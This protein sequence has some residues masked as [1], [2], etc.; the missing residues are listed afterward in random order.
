MTQAFARM[1]RAII[2]RYPALGFP[3]FRRYW[4]A[5]FAS[6]GA[7]QLVTLGQGWLIFELS[8][9]A[10]QLGVLGA[11]AS[12]PNILMTLLGGVIADR[13]DRRRILITTSALTAS[14]L[15]LLTFLDFSGLVTVWHV[16]VIASLVSLISGLD[17]P[18]R[19]S[20]FPLL[21]DRY[22]FLSG[23]AMNAFIWQ[24]TRMA[25]PAAGGLII[26]LAGDTWP[27]FALATVGFLVMSLVLTTIHVVVPPTAHESP[28]EQLKEGFRFIYRTELFRWLLGLTFVGMFFSQSYVQI[29]PVFAD[30]LGADEAGYG[31]LLSAGGLGSVVG[32]LLIGMVQE[33]P[34]LG[35]IMLGGAVGSALALIAF[36]LGIPTGSLPL[37]LLLV[38]L[39]AGA[40]SAFM[41]ISMTVLQ[42]EVPDALRG[43][44][45]GIHTIGYSLV[46]L[47]GLFLG[48]M[49]DSLG[50]GW[51]VITG[52]AVY[53]AAVA[54]TTLAK[55]S[56]RNLDGR[57]LQSPP[58]STEPPGVA[59]DQPAAAR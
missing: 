15:A 44:V 55:P 10:L 43:R 50:A 21:L 7:T 1:G 39:I 17:W 40:A 35:W 22:A 20:I 14:L 33:S 45:M 34:R 19:A 46:P 5:S 38:F 53:L 32:T 27:I 30:L 49:A 6:V 54:L 28:F 3:K 37:A 52:A 51:A 23:S 42:L 11:A 16:L 26:A 31:Y 4:F 25:I 24:S 13:F 48:G 47:G 18:A 58:P 56:I 59:E 8:G 41:I 2:T 36:A 9:S 12:I 57:A 29:M